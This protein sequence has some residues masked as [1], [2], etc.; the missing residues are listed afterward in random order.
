MK[1]TKEH[2]GKRLLVK[3]N[4]GY[5]SEPIEAGLMEVSPSGDYLKIQFVR[6]DSTTYT[7]W[8]SVHNYQL[9][10]V[11]ASKAEQIADIVKKFKDQSDSVTVTEEQYKKES[12]EALARELKKGKWVQGIC[13]PPSPDW[14]ATNSQKYNWTGNGL[15]MDCKSTYKKHDVVKEI[16]GDLADI[17]SK[18]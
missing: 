1:I 2:L 12:Q 17:M 13:N 7:D 18:L 11:L 8:V 9:V 3:K 4:V 5:Y 10:E 14:K 16:V 15:A 6:A